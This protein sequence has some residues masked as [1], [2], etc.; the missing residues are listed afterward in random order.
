MWESLRRSPRSLI[1]CT[2]EGIPLPIFPS[3]LDLSAY[4]VVIGPREN[5]F[6]GPAAA[7][8][9]PGQW[10][11]RTTCMCYT[12]AFTGTSWGGDLTKRTIKSATAHPYH[13]RTWPPF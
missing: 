7:L 3:R 12:D 6:P 2:G 13:F 8:N 4:E 11:R 10:T 5:G 1:G 9:G